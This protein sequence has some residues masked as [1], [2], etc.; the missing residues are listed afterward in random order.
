MQVLS[1]NPWLAWL[2]IAL[3]LAAIEAASVDFTF[4]MLSGGAL[5]AMVAAALGTPVWLQ[6]VIFVVFAAL[7][8]QAV[9]PIVRRRFMD[10]ESF[11][12]IGSPALVGRAA[13][14]VQ[15]VTEFDGR[16]WLAGGT[17]S[18]RLPAGAA[19]CEP[20]QEVRVLAIKGAT[21]I[22]TGDAASGGPADPAKT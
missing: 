5:A 8:V 1:E 20:G 21:A 22:V 6:V 13:R 11:H 2:G 16:V 4:I 15:T 7:L 14:V 10:H 17:W 12:G 9:R 3:V 18:A 19:T